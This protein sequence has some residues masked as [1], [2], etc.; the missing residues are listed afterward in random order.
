MTNRE[1]ARKL[2]EKMPED[3]LAQTV[4][5]LQDIYFGDELPKPKAPQSAEQKEGYISLEEAMTLAVYLCHKSPYNPP[6]LS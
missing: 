5:V 6:R 4:A 1:L 2:I 3:K